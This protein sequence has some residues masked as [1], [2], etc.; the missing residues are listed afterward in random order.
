M[1]ALD[2]LGLLCRGIT[3][4]ALR[5]TGLSIVLH[6]PVELPPVMNV[7]NPTFSIRPIAQG[8]VVILAGGRSGRNELRCGHAR[9][10]RAARQ[11]R[12]RA[13]GRGGAGAGEPK[14]EAGH[15]G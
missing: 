10:C 11:R 8:G 14:A 6:L 4:E 1:E 2:S 13:G 7:P 15:V 9:G 3:N 12:R 5:D